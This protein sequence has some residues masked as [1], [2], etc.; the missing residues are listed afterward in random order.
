MDQLQK[1]SEDYNQWYVI[2]TGHMI[3]IVNTTFPINFGP[4][5]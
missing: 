2:F 4:E 1:G 3:N 5:N